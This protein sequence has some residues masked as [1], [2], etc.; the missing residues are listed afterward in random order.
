MS[1]ELVVSGGGTITVATEDLFMAVTT[2]RAVSAALAELEQRARALA[3]F[4][5]GQRAVDLLRVAGRIG[6]LATRLEELGVRL[7]SAADAYSLVEQVATSAAA[8]AVGQGGYW[9]GLLGPAIVA[10]LP[11]AVLVGSVLAGGVLVAT[12]REV[13]Q[14][15][16]GVLLSDPRIVNLVR[17]AV[18]GADDAARGALHVPWLPSQLAD[19][20]MTGLFGREETAQGLLLGLQA[21]GVLSPSAAAVRRVDTRS[22]EPPSSVADLVRR[23]PGGGKD[24]P[25]VRIERYPSQQGDRYVVYLGGTVEVGLGAAADPWDLSSDLAGIAG[26][27][28]DSAQAAA[29]A[30]AAAGIGPDDGVLLVGYSQGGLLASRLASDPRFAV[31]GIVTVGSPGASIEVPAEL[32]VLALEHSDDLV[33]ALSGVPNARPRPSAQVTVSRSA[34]DGRPPIA[35]AAVP[36]HSLAQYRVTAGLVDHCEEGRVA[37]VRQRI[38][39]FL[40]AGRGESSRWRAERVSGDGRRPAAAAP[41]R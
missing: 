25:Q 33:P 32:P 9:A 24:Q 28:A 39:A 7:A 26:S 8:T 4:P 21:T 13:W 14:A 6:E 36:A 15:N 12:S 41:V 10:A 35:A 2:C 17:L 34:F 18:D 3:W 40:P 5:D 37:A 16:R 30:M 1:D 31:A 27:R 20:R 23:I 11:P 19:D 29:D 22:T 38:L